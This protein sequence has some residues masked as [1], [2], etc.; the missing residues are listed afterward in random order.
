MGDDLDRFN[1]ANS[2]SWLLSDFGINGD[3]P[4]DDWFDF[5][6]GL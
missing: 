3:Y 6:E 1:A 5:L 4:W 2:L